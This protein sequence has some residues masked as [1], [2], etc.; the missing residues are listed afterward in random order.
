LI[1]RPRE[2]AD[3]ATP[4]GTSLA[5]ELLVRLAELLH[6]VDARRRATYVM[7]T[8]APA[9]AR[10]PAAFGHMLGAADMLINGAV[11]L[12][13]VGEPGDAGFEALARVA[14]NHYVPS[15]VLAGGAPTS[16][17]TIA[18]LEGRDARSG[19]ATAYVCRGY[20]CDEPATTPEMLATQ[21]DALTGGR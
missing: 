3:N 11:E 4:S 8:L 10:Y 1:T 17:P 5:V 14:A 16:D 7:E 2:V 18:L 19:R 9:V 12:A 21:L 13:I 20:A 6:D 15:L